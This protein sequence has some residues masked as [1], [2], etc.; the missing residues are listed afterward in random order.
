MFK[1]HFKV[2]LR[3]LLGKKVYSAINILGLAIGM[4][5]CLL[6]FQYVAFEYSFDSFNENGASLYR[7]SQTT[8]QSGGEPSI[9]STT[10]WAMAP[11]LAAEVPEVVRFARLHPEYGN[12][13]VFDPNQ[14]DKAFEEERVYYADSTFFQMFSYPLVSGNPAHALA[15]PGTVM[16][17]ESTAR[18]YFGDADPVGQSLEVRAWISGTFRV[19]GIFRDVPANSHLQFDMLLPMVDLLEKSAFSDPATGWGWTNFITYVQLHENVDR[20]A[21]AQKFTKI[22]TRNREEDWRQT[23]TTGY[24]NTQPL[25]DVHLNADIATPRAVTSSYRAVYFFTIIGLVILLIALVNYINLTTARALDRAR[26]VGVRKVVGAKRGQLIVQFLAESM[27]VILIAFAMA[28]AL[29]D[30]FRPALNKLAGLGMTDALWMNANFW[31]ALLALL[32]L[33]IVLAG[34]YPAFVLSSFQPVVVLKGRV[35]KT[36]TSAWL[37]RGLVVFQFTASIVLL[38]GITIVYTQL[39]HMRHRDLGINLAQILTVPAP[40]VLPEGADRANAVETFTQE[41]RRLSAVEQTATSAT[42][43]G[44]GFN[45]YTNNIRKAAADPSTGIDGVLTNIDTSFAALYGMELVAGS[46]FKNTATPAEGEPTPIIVNETAAYALDFDTPEEAINQEVNIE[47]GLN[48]IVGVFKDI[49]WSSAHATREHMFFFFRPNNAQISVKVSTGNLSE[50][51]AAVEELYKQLFPGNP[52]QYAFSDETF[53]AQYRQD[54]QFARLVSVFTVLAILIACLGLFGLAAFTAEQ[55]TKE[56]G[57]RK[58][59]GASVQSIVSLLAKNFLGMIVLSF[60]LATPL[61]WYAMHEWLQ[62]FVYRIDMQ[63]WMFAFAGLL[64]VLVAL[65][66]ISFQAIKAA[67]ANPVDSLRNE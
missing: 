64:A 58:V 27:L 7:I 15:E 66:T 4:A 45:Y 32:C 13:I 10:G 9:E 23:N 60:L 48:L 55:R 59:L 43:P 67:L 51:I 54:Q 19:D 11:A 26:E 42:V 50:T 2:A 44:K 56:I 65:F 6:I 17:S 47:G 49:S 38:I 3:N 53:D 22:V 18:K 29:A 16:L 34:L 36:A 61:A 1:N 41:L 8:V 52:F 28:V 5:C 39:N 20:S 57:I 31:M 14:P 63:W 33:T 12:A 37:R 46:G 21:V 40:R 30:V 62:D 35:S 25:Q 24:V